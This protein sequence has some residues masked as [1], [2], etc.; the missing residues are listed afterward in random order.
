MSTLIPQLSSKDEKI[1][2]KLDELL[3]GDQTDIQLDIP[4]NEGNGQWPSSFY[5]LTINHLCPGPLAYMLTIHKDGINLVDM[6]NL[7]FW[8][9]HFNNDSLLKVLIYFGADN[10]SEYQSKRTPLQAAQS[11]KCSEKVLD[12]LK[13]KPSNEEKLL[14]QL[15]WKVTLEGYFKSMDSSRYNHDEIEAK[16]QGHWDTLYSGL[17]NGVIT[18]DLDLLKELF[19]YNISKLLLIYLTSK[20]IDLEHQHLIDYFIEKIRD[21]QVIKN[22]IEIKNE[23][24]NMNNLTEDGQSLLDQLKEINNPWTN[25]LF[26]QLLFI[27]LNPTTQSETE[28]NLLVSQ[29]NILCLITILCSKCVFLDFESYM[30]LV[31]SVFE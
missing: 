30:E 7:M 19:P 25:I 15:E 5:P 21:D 28:T 9:I 27:G 17:Y 12:L 6:E 8:A 3:S 13:N 24:N 31:D 14:Y 18:G 11:Y 2:K 23:I 20:A 29:S 1:I 26:N 16:Y 10:E 22:E 4:I